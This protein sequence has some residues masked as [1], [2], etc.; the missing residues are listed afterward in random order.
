MLGTF[1]QSFKPWLGYNVNFG[2]T[3]LSENYSHGEAFVPASGSSAAPSSSFARIDWCKCYELT[4]SSVFEGPKSRRFS[5]FGQFGGGG[6]FFVHRKANLVND[7][8]I[9]EQ[10]R[11]AM[12]FGVG[13]NYKLTSHL[14]GA[15]NIADF[16]IKVPISHFHPTTDSTSRCLGYSQSPTHLQSAWFIDLAEQRNQKPSII[17]VE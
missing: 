5:T 3:R 13:M 2:Y 1:H 11:P 8:P 16:S 15:L 14:I 4:I 17:P 10:T 7:M 12:L 6:L 9:H